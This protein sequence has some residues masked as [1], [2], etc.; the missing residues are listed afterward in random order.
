MGATVIGTEICNEPGYC[1]KIIEYMKTN[2]GLEIQSSDELIYAASDTSGFVNY[3]SCQKNLSLKLIKICNAQRLLSSG[4]RCG[5]GEI[6]LPKTQP[7]S[8]I[9]PGK[10]NPDQF[11]FTL[12]LIIH[13]LNLLTFME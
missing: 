10:V 9:M 6:H 8:S 13:L 3:Y 12:L 1:E 5:F 7:G 4:L 11:K 2:T